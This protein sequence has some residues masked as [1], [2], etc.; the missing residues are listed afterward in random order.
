M[1]DQPIMEPYS[2]GARFK[3]FGYELVDVLGQPCI[4]LNATVVLDDDR[5]YRGPLCCFA[6]F[7]LFR[8]GNPAEW[9]AL[10]LNN[11]DDIAKQIVAELTEAKDA[12][13]R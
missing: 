12:N 7:R 6:P 1:Q 13:N 9:C 5:E 10:A 4:Y 3:E 11:L 8:V 2:G